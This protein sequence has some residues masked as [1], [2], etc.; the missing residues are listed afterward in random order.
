M[1]FGAHSLIAESAAF[2]SP[3][4]ERGESQG[5]GASE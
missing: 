4:E 1:R 5:F 2:V 3:G